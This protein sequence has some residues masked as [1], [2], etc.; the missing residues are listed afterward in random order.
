MTQTQDPLH[1]ELQPLPGLLV[2]GKVLGEGERLLVCLPGFGNDRDWFDPI[3]PLVPTGY[4]VAVFDLPGFWGSTWEGA[5]PLGAAELRAWLAAIRAHFQVERV[6]LLGFSLGGRVV[7]GMVA[8][9][10]EWVGGLVLLAPDGLRVHP[11][12]GF[13]VYTWLGRGLFRF[14]MRR[15]AGLLGIVRI[16]YALRMLPATTYHLAL[17]QLETPERRRRLHEAWMAW[18]GIRP[19]LRL[20]AARSGEFR[21][22]WHVVWGRQDEILDVRQ[23]ERFARKVPGTKWYPLEGGHFFLRHPQPDLRATLATVFDAM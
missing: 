11:V 14:V 18:S 19:D 3:L 9:A 8:A 2:A 13:A 4:R 7:M 10:P 16:L 17:R 6:D 22:T 12:Y 15:P 5:H 20:L 23:G 1:F 21:L